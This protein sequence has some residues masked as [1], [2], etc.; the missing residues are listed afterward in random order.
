MKSQRTAGLML[1]GIVVLLMMLVAGPAGA[2]TSGGAT[3]EHGSVASGTA[4]AE[5]GSTASGAS[6]AEN[7][8]TASGQAHAHDGSTASGCSRAE[9]GSTASGADCPRHVPPPHQP[10]HQPPHVTPTTVR[11]AAATPAR[12]A[13]T[14]TWTAPLAAMAG[15][16]VALGSAL[17]LV[18]RGR[19]RPI[20]G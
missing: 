8:S 12:L 4:H 11:P 7:W 10:P 19:R 1:G 15:L 13:L 5:N 16:S 3:A 2:Q 9:D 18:G 6:H 14:G 20:E 17:Q